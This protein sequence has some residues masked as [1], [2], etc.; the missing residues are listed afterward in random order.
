MASNQAGVVRAVQE[1][2]LR[3]EPKLRVHFTKED[4]TRT[5]L[6]MFGIDYDLVITNT[7]NPSWYFIKPFISR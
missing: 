6:K 2:L 5:E 1:W 7:R 3:D 4:F